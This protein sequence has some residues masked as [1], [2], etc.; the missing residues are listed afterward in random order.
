MNHYFPRERGRLISIIMPVIRAANAWDQRYEVEWYVNRCEMHGWCN[1]EDIRRRCAERY[2]AGKRK[3]SL[4]GTKTKRRLHAKIR[5]ELTQINPEIS[6]LVNQLSQTEAAKQYCLGNEKA[7][8]PLVGQLLKC[9]VT[10]QV[11]REL[12]TQKLKP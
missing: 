2:L 7:I 5:K 3:V 6:A 9:G 1:T 4:P 8:N 12:L 10:A 11:A